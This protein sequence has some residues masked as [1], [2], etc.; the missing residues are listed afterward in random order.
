M[1]NIFPDP[2][3]LPFPGA[4]HRVPEA[5]FGQRESGGEGDRLTDAFKHVFPPQHPG[6]RGSSNHR[7]RLH[8]MVQEYLGNLSNRASTV[9]LGLEDEPLARTSSICN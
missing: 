2:G 7:Q 6:L 8:Y 3:R 4:G 9:L 1:C 5:S